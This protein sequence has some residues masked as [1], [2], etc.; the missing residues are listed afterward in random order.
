MLELIKETG[1]ETNAVIIETETNKNH[2]KLTH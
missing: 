2:Y 1:L